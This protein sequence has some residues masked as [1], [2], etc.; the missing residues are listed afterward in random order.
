VVN[1]GPNQSSLNRFLC[2]DTWNRDSVNRRRIDICVSK[3][4]GGLLILD[5]T[6]LEKTG[7]HM[8]G[9]GYLYDHSQRKHILCH[10]MVSTY[11][12]NAN[13]NNPLF[14]DLYVKKEIAETI[15]PT[16]RKPQEAKT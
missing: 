3:R 9:V 11:Y 2:N 13:E 5:D 6:L 4:K 7:K 12:V 10:S 16:F 14:M 8:E 1:S 15:N